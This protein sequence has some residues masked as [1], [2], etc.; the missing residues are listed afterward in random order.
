MN[1][2]LDAPLKRKASLKKKISCL[3]VDF[4][5]KKK[6]GTGAYLRLFISRQM[7]LE[8]QS[9]NVFFKFAANGSDAYTINEA[10]QAVFGSNIMNTICPLSPGLSL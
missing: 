8:F 3:P 4:G 5:G 1:G 9:V 2:G 10:L 6:Q 7:P